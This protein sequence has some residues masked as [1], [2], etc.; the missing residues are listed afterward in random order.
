MHVAMNKKD[1]KKK[2]TLR[3]GGTNLKF[4]VHLHEEPFGGYLGTREATCG[5]C[6]PKDVLKSKLWVAGKLTFFGERASADQITMRSCGLSVGPAPGDH[7]PS[8]K[9]E[10]WTRTQTHAGRAPCNDGGRDWSYASRSPGLLPPLGAGRGL[11]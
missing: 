8:M 9:K 11:E 10:I 3:R 4:S 1:K 6:P 5:P 2:K 7:C